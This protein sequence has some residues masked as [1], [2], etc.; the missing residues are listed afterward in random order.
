MVH[1]SHPT[2][3]AFGASFFRYDPDSGR[4]ERIAHTGYVADTAY[5]ALVWAGQFWR[6]TASEITDHGGLNAEVFEPNQIV[7]R[8]YI[9]EGDVMFCGDGTAIWDETIGIVASVRPTRN[10]L[11]MQWD[12]S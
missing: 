9:E 10:Q 1:N 3:R 12:G 11:L 2:F 6:K 8:I 5:E 7:E 4:I